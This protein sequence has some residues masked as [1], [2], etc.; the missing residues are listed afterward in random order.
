VSGDGFTAQETEIGEFKADAEG[1]VDLAVAIPDDVGGLHG[2]VLRG[3]NEPVAKV[4]FVVE[5]SIVGI[6]PRS[7]PAARP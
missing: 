5:T 6:S 7:G 2:L 4:Y 3:D 1:R